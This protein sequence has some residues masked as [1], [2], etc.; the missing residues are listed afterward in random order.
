MSEW[1]TKTLAEFKQSATIVWRAQVNKAP[2]GRQFAGI[3]KFAIK[4]DGKEQITKDGISFPYDAGTLPETL[5]GI[6]DLL[7]KLKGGKVRGED[8]KVD[9]EKQYYFLGLNF[10]S[11][12]PVYC[13]GIGV[14][15][16][17]KTTRNKGDAQLFT[18]EFAK[19][20]RKYVNKHKWARKLYTEPE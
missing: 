20:A 13:A 4:K 5:D 16:K 11:S 8:V 18:E 9:T 12:V 7:T 2:D 6:I 1:K 3:R 15:G 14:D 19:A 10:K 17:V